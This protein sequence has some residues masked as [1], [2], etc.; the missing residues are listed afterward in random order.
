METNQPDGDAADATQ[1]V[2]SPHDYGKRNPLEI[3][4]ALQNLLNRGDFV[5]V[6]YQGGQLVSRILDV[7]VA[8]RVFV[9]DWGGV[10]SQNVGLLASQRNQFS[11]QPDGVRLKFE[12]PAAKET[13]FEG[14]RAFRSAFPDVLYHMQRR[15]YFRVGT[16]VL[17]P[18]MCRGRWPDGAEFQY[19]VQD[20]SLGGVALRTADDK[21]SQLPLEAVLRGVT[22]NVEDHGQ[23]T[24]DLQLVSRRTVELA[25]GGTRYQLGFRFVSLPGH[26]ENTLQRIVTQLEMKRR[27]LTRG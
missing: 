6:Q 15:E 26:V 10:E 19:E 18:F 11:A 21:A 4:V 22:L 16:P 2:P 7:N 25:K 20:M 27:A 24:L 13:D 23:L 12:T 14:R 5:G 8:S 9:F 17:D 3:G 1:D